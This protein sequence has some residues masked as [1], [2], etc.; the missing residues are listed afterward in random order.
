MIG[1][2]RRLA[3]ALVALL[4]LAGCGSDDKKGQAPAPA[5]TQA[6]A[7]TQ[8]TR[9]AGG[10]KPVPVPQPR[11]PT[12]EKKPSSAL[13]T[14]RKWTLTFATNCG[15]FTVAL[16]LKT[17]PNAA[18]SMVALAKSGYFDNTLFHRIVPEFVIQGGDPSAT[19]NGGPGY[20]TV[21]KPPSGASYT[22]GVVA[23]AKTGA[24]K[25]GTGGSQF[26][27]V[28]GPDAQLPAEYAVLGKVTKGLATVDRIGQ[29]GDPNTEQPSEPVV[30][31]HV[32]VGGG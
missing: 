30:I 1:G 22:H 13:A 25:P 3:T 6:Q 2:L 18:A 4:A 19:G 29:L 23:M 15:S 31:Q 11:R 16:N 24:E 9:T 26:F 21:D 28:T 8:P 27:V 12:R 17:G 20:K 7:Q 10:C 32:T 5:Q 14:S